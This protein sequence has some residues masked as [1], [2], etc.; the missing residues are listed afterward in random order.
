MDDFLAPYDAHIQAIVRR[1]RLLL[2][3]SIPEAVETQDRDN[4]GYGL[5][6]G[7]KGLVCVITPYKDHV[8]L[9]LY[10]AVELPD[11]HNLLEGSGKRHRHIRLTTEAQLESPALQALILAAVKHKKERG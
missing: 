1:A 11:P 7:Y 3:E 9:G 4:L 2:L 8:N 10:D 6:P 5:T